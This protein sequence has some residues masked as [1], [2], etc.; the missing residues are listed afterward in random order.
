MLTYSKTIDIDII[1][2]NIKYIYK[3]LFIKLF[4]II[5]NSPPFFV[6]DHMIIKNKIL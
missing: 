5:S 1:L 6:T 3:N 2:K 4:N